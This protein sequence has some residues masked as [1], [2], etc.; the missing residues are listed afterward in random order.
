MS[1]LVGIRFY[2]RLIQI[3]KLKKNLILKIK[4]CLLFTWFSIRFYLRLIQIEKFKKC[5]FENKI[6]F[7]FYLI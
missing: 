3:E 7:T 5:N 6:F 2:L 1:N 4:Y